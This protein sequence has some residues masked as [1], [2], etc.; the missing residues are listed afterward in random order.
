LKSSHPIQTAEYAV[1]TKIDSEPALRWWVP[2]ILNEREKLI[3][4]VKTRYL[5]RYQK[6]GIDL[7]RTVE[8]ALRIDKE[9]NTTY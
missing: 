9:T 7:P 5:K 8:E 2:H 3:S 1:Q 4:A 6:F